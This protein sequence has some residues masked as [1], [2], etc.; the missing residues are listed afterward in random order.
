MATILRSLKFVHKLNVGPGGR[1]LGSAALHRLSG[2]RPLGAQPLA[3][4]SSEQRNYVTNVAVKQNYNNRGNIDL[5]LNDVDRKIKN[6]GNI[7][8]NDVEDLLQAVTEKGSI[9]TTQALLMIRCCGDFLCSESLQTRQALVKNVWDTITGLGL[10]LDISHYNALLLINLEN[11]TDFSPLDILVELKEKNIQPNRVTF[12]RLIEQ[13]CNKGDI[14][15]ATKILEHMSA[16]EIPINEVIFNS[17]IKGHSEAGDVQSAVKILEIMKQAGIEPSSRSYTAVLCTHAKSGDIEAIR[18]TLNDCKEKDILLANKEILEVIYTL[19]LNKQLEHIDEIMSLLLKGSTYNREAIPFIYKLIEKNRIETA[20]KLLKSLVKNP[21]RQSEDEKTDSGQF[22]IRKLV[23]HDVNPETVVKYCKIMQEEKLN[24]NAFILAIYTAFTNDKHHLALPLLKALKESGAEIREHYFYPLFVS[25]SKV[26][27]LQGILNTMRTMIFDFNIAP[28]IL[29]VKDY[30][31]PYMVENP[32]SNCNTLVENNLPFSVAANSMLLHL[33]SQN[34]TQQAAKFIVST[35]M[36]YRARIMIRPLVNA[37]EYTKDVKSFMNILHYQYIHMLNDNY[38]NDDEN[39]GEQISAKQFVNIALV[40]AID[41]LS[42]FNAECIIEVLKELSEKGINIDDQAAEKIKSHIG[43]NLTPE[44]NDIINVLVSGDLTPVPLESVQGRRVFSNQG[45]LSANLESLQQK[46]ETSIE[47]KIILLQT[48]AKLRNHEGVVKILEEIE[49][50][51]PTY[52]VGL[53]ASLVDY[54]SRSERLEDAEK[55]FKKMLEINPE[56][57]ID[58]AKILNYA[59]LLLKNNRIEDALEALTVPVNDVDSDRTYLCEKLLSTVKKNSPDRIDEFFNVLNDRRFFSKVTVSLLGSLIRAPLD[60]G[61]TTKAIEKFRWACENFKLTPQRN[62]LMMKLINDEDAKSLQYVTDLC[63]QIYG[64]MNALFDLAIA[65]FDCNRPRQARKILETPGLRLRRERVLY[66]A[67]KLSEQGDTEQ[68]ENLIQLLTGLFFDM[69]PLYILMLQTYE[70]NGNWEKCLSLWT[71]MQEDNIQPSSVFM[72]HLERVLRKCNQEI[73]FATTSV[74]FDDDSGL[75][76]SK[77]FH[78]ALT[79]GNLDGAKEILKSMPKKQQGRYYL[80]LIEA[81]SNVNNVDMAV[82][83]LIESLDSKIELDNEAQSVITKLF[84]QLIEN[85]DFDTLCE[86]M[87]KS[88]NIG[89]RKMPL[90]FILNKCY[91]EAGKYQELI[92]NLERVLDDPSKKNLAIKSMFHNTIAAKAMHNNSE[93]EEQVKKFAQKAIS[94]EIYGPI[95]T[96]WIHEYLN[97]NSEAEKIWEEHLKKNPYFHSIS[98][99]FICKDRGVWSKIPQLAEKLAEASALQFDDKRR[100]FA[101]YFKCILESEEPN[102]YELAYE[103]LRHAVKSIGFDRV[104]PKV[105]STLEENLP[106]GPSIQAL[107]TENEERTQEKATG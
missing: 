105:I 16:Q 58:K 89:T 14:A 79:A 22:F 43:K 71:Q 65:F 49:K 34:K 11:E 46:A 17:L 55:W 37:L 51:N 67:Q 7:Y 74:E 31:I 9:T 25:Y 81:C 97:G 23:T 35:N 77:T 66:T 13:Y 84:A 73:P 28:S 29:A 1:R 20:F 75:V 94:G 53:C 88:N 104:N 107:K 39:T 12:Q 95:N 33:L 61:D 8:K 90:N 70:K 76:G 42:K 40:R 6:F 18:N 50:E 30:I 106:N 99:V 36:P 92:S 56:C 45:D 15:G 24:Q 62:I 80:S 91:F 68:L 78:D 4:L 69:D 19:A 100:T 41:Q 10:Q 21:L 101:T 96:V 59:D 60:S 26:N 72:G 63:T 83:N 57:K 27:N 87:S 86:I 5:M 85:N 52:T 3:S 64:E 103:C 48:Y 54:Y 47:F 82:Q 38:N 32:I 2:T 98:A 102:K 44:I 93:V